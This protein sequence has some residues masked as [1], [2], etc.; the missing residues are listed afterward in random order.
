MTGLTLTDLTLW[1]GALLAGLGLVRLLTVRDPMTRLV[2]LNITGAGTLLALVGLS[3]RAQAPDP[4]PQALALTGIV[5]TVAF[6]GVGLILARSLT[7]DAPSSHP[8]A[9]RRDDNADRR[10]STGQETR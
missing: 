3:I 7:D 8:A 2:A 4:V 10:T 6:T 5:I 1:L 9:D